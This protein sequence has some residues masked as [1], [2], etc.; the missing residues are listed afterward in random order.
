MTVA[1][2][3]LSWWPGNSQQKRP[4]GPDP[5]SPSGA[6]NAVRFGNVISKSTVR[7][8]QHATFDHFSSVFRSSSPS[9]ILGRVVADITRSRQHEAG[10][11]G[12]GRG[13]VQ[14]PLKGLPAGIALHVSVRGLDLEGRRMTPS[15]HARPRLIDE[16][17]G[18]TWIVSSPPGV[19][20][21]FLVC[22]I[23]TLPVYTA[24]AKS[25]SI[26]NQDQIHLF[27]DS[28]FTSEDPPPLAS[29]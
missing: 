10:F 4:A 21:S 28:T 2:E 5:R 16:V 3:L 18:M 7:Q 6:G 25:R 29:S 17:F 22:L 14:K 23:Q 15:A 26:N 13:V 12:A 8:F 11:V 20:F 1:I 27:D 24:A 19:F 9:T